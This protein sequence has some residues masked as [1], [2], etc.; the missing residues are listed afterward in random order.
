MK[1]KKFVESHFPVYWVEAFNM[2][3]QKW[4]PV[5]PL[6]TGTINKPHKIEPPASDS[7]NDMSYVVAFNEDGSMKD[8]TRRYTKAYNAK[9]RRIRADS[10]KEG[11]RWWKK[12]LRVFKGEKEVTIYGCQ[13]MSK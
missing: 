13:C 2:A 1:S 8:V 10:T 4:V 6:V 7:L 3:H 9:T 12:S 11:Q 5:D